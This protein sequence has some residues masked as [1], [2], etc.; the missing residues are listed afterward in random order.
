MGMLMGGASFV[1][2]NSNSLNIAAGR[3]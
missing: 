1:L 2:G 3:G